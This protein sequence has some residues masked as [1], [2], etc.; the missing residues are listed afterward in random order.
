MIPAYVAPADLRF[1]ILAYNEI[2][3][4]KQANQLRKLAALIALMQKN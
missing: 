3:N 4:I 2:T 1:T